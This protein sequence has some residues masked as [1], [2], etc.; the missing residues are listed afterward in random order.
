V[1]DL[2]GE[3][4]GLP[5][6]FFDSGVGGISVLAEAVKQLPDERY[7]YFGDSANAPYGTKSVEEVRDLSMRAVDFL[8][9]KGIKALVVAC[10]TATSVA[11]NEIREKLDIPIIGMEPA[12]KPAVEM[13]RE[14]KIVVMATPLTVR[15]KKFN[16]LM[17]KYKDQ[18][19]IIP[20]PCPGL[21]ELIEQGKTEGKEIAGYLEKLLA[22]VTG[23]NLRALVLGCTHYLFIKKE[24]LKL[25]SGHTAVIHG[26]CGTVMQLRR[27]LERE[28]LLAEN[29]EI[30]NM[31]FKDKI[32]FFT[33]GDKKQMQPLSEFLL[34][35][36]LKNLEC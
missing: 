33:S 9:N 23:E 7:I 20:L 22:P 32:R 17:D 36:A 34:R 6:G 12:L 14:G 1:N 16:I 4:T 10:N 31:D 24:V 18:A 28:N 30:G 35:A 25:V 21:V 27:V 8:Y 5:I 11:I 2:E 29:R 3:R 13:G 26:N 15:E 19:E